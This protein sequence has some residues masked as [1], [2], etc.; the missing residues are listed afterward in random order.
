MTFFTFLL[1]LNA[2]LILAYATLILMY[3]KKNLNWSIIIRVLFLTLFTLVVF[4]HY[5]SD[6]QF[7]VML[8]LW[9]IFEAFYLKK[10]HHAQPGK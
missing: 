5:E 4:A 2:L 6:Q 1:C 8:C 9:V 10:I 7:I 3:Q